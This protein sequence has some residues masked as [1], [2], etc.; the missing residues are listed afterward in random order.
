MNLQEFQ[1]LGNSNP[2]AQ[3]AWA[4][5]R[6]KELRK[7]WICYRCG[8][9]L[10]ISGFIWKSRWNRFRLEHRLLPETKGSGYFCDSCADTREAGIDY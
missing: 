9:R 6:D 1:T 8:R 7:L 2:E 3:H 5:A 4:I 10:P